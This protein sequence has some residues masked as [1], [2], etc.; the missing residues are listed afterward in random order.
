MKFGKMSLDELDLMRKRTIQTMN[1]SAAG[2]VEEFDCGGVVM[3]LNDEK[4]ET[5]FGISKLENKISYR[6]HVSP[7]IRLINGGF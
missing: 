1:Y 5:Q 6:G 2:Y 7:Y 3:V 4:L